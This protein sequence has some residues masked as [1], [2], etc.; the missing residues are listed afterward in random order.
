DIPPARLQAFCLSQ[1]PAGSRVVSRIDRGGRPRVEDPSTEG[2]VWAHASPGGVVFPLPREAPIVPVG[3]QPCQPPAVN[4]L[5]RVEV[6]EPAFSHQP[7][8]CRSRRSTRCSRAAAYWRST[9]PWA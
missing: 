7:P 3:R 4:L 6:S 8:A 9:F 2:S 5:G 1:G